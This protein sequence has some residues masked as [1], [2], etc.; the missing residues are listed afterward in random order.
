MKQSQRDLSP[1]GGAEPRQ[2][3]IEAVSQTFHAAVAEKGTGSAIDVWVHGFVYESFGIDWDQPAAL[4][5]ASLP[6]S[7]GE[8]TLKEEGIS[9]SNVLGMT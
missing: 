9:A 2:A 5:S 6:I 3:R 4:A 8:D 1:H 7:R